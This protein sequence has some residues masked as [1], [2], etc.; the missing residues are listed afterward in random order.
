MKKASE[1]LSSSKAA[2]ARHLPRGQWLE[3]FTPG[4][5]MKKHQP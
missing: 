1:S 3:Y 2:R 4:W 5:H